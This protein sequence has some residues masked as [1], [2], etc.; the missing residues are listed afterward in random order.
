MVAATVRKKRKWW[1]RKIFIYINQKMPGVSILLPSR[2]TQSQ[3]LIIYFLLLSFFEFR[4]KTLIILSWWSCAQP[5]TT[6]SLGGFDNIKMALCLW[7]LVVNN[8]D[9]LLFDWSGLSILDQSVNVVLGAVFGCRDFEDVGH[10]L[11]RLL[12][13]P[14]GYHLRATMKRDVETDGQVFFYWFQQ[15][16]TTTHL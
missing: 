15:N 2:I 4:L 3:C 7:C 11:E 5:P 9:L 10:A 16:K 8:L 13:V 14:I 12:R 6:A 1:G